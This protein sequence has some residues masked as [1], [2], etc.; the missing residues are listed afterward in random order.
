MSKP[1]H[2][3]PLWERVWLGPHSKA[4]LH[5]GRIIGH[6]TVNAFAFYDEA[7]KLPFYDK[8]RFENAVR[9]LTVWEPRERGEYVLHAQAKRVLRIIIGPAPDDPE[10]VAWWRGRLVSVRLARSEGTE[11][12]FAVEPPVPLP[13]EK[14]AEPPPAPKKRARRKKAG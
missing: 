8:L 14:P 5:A 9:E 7:K 6:R 4:Y 13:E 10:Y 11:P 2:E 1:W 3:K 12:E